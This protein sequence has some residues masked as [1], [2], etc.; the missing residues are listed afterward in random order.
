MKTIDFLDVSGTPH[1][2]TSEKPSCT[3][4][5]ADNPFAGYTPS[6]LEMIDFAMEMAVI[7][8]RHLSDSERSIVLQRLLAIKS[9][10]NASI[11]WRSSLYE[12]V[13][14][15]FL[16]AN[17]DGPIDVAKHLH[18]LSFVQHCVDSFFKINDFEILSSERKSNLTSSLFSG[19]RYTVTLPQTV[20]VKIEDQMSKPGAILYVE[21]DRFHLSENV[22]WNYAF[23]PTFFK[24]HTQNKSALGHGEFTL[25]CF[26]LP[27]E[28]GF[29]S[30]FSAVINVPIDLV[31][32]TLDYRNINGNGHP[33]EIDYQ[34]PVD[35]GN[36]LRIIDVQAMKHSEIQARITN[37]K[38]D[39][40]KKY[41][42][43]HFKES[44]MALPSDDFIAM[45]TLAISLKKRIETTPVHTLISDIP[46]DLHPAVLFGVKEELRSIDLMAPLL[47]RGCYFYN[48]NYSFNVND[49]Y[50]M[51]K[52]IDAQVLL[53]KM[54]A[55]NI[56]VFKAVPAH[57]ESIEMGKS[58]EKSGVTDIEFI[59][60]ASNNIFSDAVIIKAAEKRVNSF[61][62]LKKIP[63][64]LVTEG[65][66]PALLGK[67]GFDPTEISFDLEA[68]M[69]S[70]KTI[71]AQAM[72]IKAVKNWVNSKN[73]PVMA[74]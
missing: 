63:K 44:I 6:A 17:F 54:V 43:E 35:N 50:A 32:G 55:L 68:F 24:N 30:E 53:D 51:N 59:F 62:K 40:I 13:S 52:T 57:F 22:S 66:L 20:S 16:D 4:F 70:N 3:S 21:Q 19:L 7:D 64:F 42:A 27:K 67:H 58:I 71:A 29:D 46:Y 33:T 15:S 45:R 5:L 36:P 37:Q 14:R 25:P 74:S 18:A 61:K 56:D 38:K 34:A 48:K 65:N 41:R 39:W 47:A 11:N 8:E 10:A 28:S 1:R 60:K 72:K 26:I 69:S 2:I 23:K 73:K 12:L 31:T 49:I 9:M